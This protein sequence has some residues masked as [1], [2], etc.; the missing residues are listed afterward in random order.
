MDYILRSTLREACYPPA[1]IRALKR[2]TP[3]LQGAQELRN[4]KVNNAKLGGKD[5]TY[6]NLSALLLAFNLSAN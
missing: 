5:P 3:P 1:V 6:E 2:T 4:R